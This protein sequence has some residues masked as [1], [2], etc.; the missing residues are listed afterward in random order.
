MRHI[1]DIIL[2]LVACTTLLAGCCYDL[3]PSSPST[4]NKP[5]TPD[6][7]TEPYAVEITSITR[8]TITFNVE[9]EDNEASYLCVVETKERV[10]EF[11]KDEYLITTLLQDFENEASNKGQTLSEYLP[12]IADKGELKDARF[13]GLSIDSPYYLIIIELD[14]ATDYAPTQ[15]IVKREFTTLSAEMSECSFEVATEVVNNSVTF[16]VSPS[17]KQHRWYLLT[18]GKE[19]F[20][21][22]TTAEDGY[23]MSQEQF[24]IY[25]LEQDIARLRGEG[26]SDQQI[27]DTLFLVGDKQLQASG[28]NAN[29]TYVYLVA[30][31]Q[32]DQEGVYVDTD[33]KRGN[34]TTGDVAASNMSFEIEV[35][36][37]GQLQASVRIT[38]SNNH[39]KYCALIQPWD[40]TDANTLMHR[41]V[42]QWGGWM[43][44]MAND[45]GVVEHSGS[46]AFSL[47]AADTDYYVIA[48][49]YDGSITTEAYMKTF[50][51]LPGGNVEEATF[52]MTATNITPYSFSLSVKSSDPTI[53]YTMNICTP[54]EYD[55][56]QFIE[57]EHEIFDYY[58]TEYKKFNPSITIAEILDQYYYNSAIVVNA[59]GLMPDTDYMGYVYALDVR[60]GRV[61]RTVTFDLVAHT[62]TLGD[63][64]PSI[65]LVGYFS[66]DEEQGTIFG[67]KTATAGK[68]ITVVK[69]GDLDEVRTLFTTMCEGDCTNFNSH[70]DAELWALT[71]GYWK[72]CK[73]SEPYTFYLADWN[74]V[75]TALAY[76][77]DVNGKIGGISR[78]YTCPTADNRGDI[79]VLRALVNELDG[80]SKSALFAP[81][82][83]FDEDNNRSTRGVILTKQ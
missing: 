20:E 25:Y 21:Q 68:A 14:A 24:F 3:E 5:I 28:L 72:T 13:T 32:I 54:K 18:V 1:K 78:L 75:Q 76:A 74:V 6:Q 17:D 31:L 59:T 34:Y 22:Y 37:V 81:S 27:I 29:T 83:V 69:Y 55:E 4:S 66:G 8:S 64:L 19:A 10:E 49:G 12:T 42:E 40:G 9:P 26:L 51:T 44:V 45:K 39:E 67:D 2:S 80:K 36:D 11:T 73:K 46:N 65:E 56:A 57:M 33:I 70:P 71:D 30:G 23:K 35:W 47:P 38:P 63:I 7:P 52:S 48:F 41:I 50:R 62:D 43:D 16:S 79:E 61:I 82:V 77:T 58:L 60:T 53:Y 15:T